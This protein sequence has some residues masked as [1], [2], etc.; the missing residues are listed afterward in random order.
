MNKTLIVGFI[1]FIKEIADGFLEDRG[2]D[3]EKGM[4]IYLE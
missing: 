3:K 2:I 1:F 4:S